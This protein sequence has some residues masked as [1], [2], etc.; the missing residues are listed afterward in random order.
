MITITNLIL[1]VIK[2]DEDNGQTS[3][4]VQ[5]RYRFQQAFILF[6]PAYRWWTDQYVM[7]S[8][9]PAIS[10]NS[11]MKVQ[12]VTWKTQYAGKIADFSMGV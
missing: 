7:G 3:V 11:A 5:R 8:L 6:A 4:L 10:S 12:A 9:V 2:V 1:T